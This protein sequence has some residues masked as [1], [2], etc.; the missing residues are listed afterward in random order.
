MRTG[1]I[2]KI[3]S[4]SGKT[5]I[6]STN[7]IKNRLNHYKTYNCKKQYKLYASLKKYGFENH[8][9]EILEEPH[10]NNL[11][12]REHYWGMIYDSLS[13]QGLNLMLPKGDSIYPVMS[14]ETKRK[15]GEANRGR[16][17]KKED[18]AK[19]VANLRGRVLSDKTRQKI[20][21]SLKGKKHSKERR[22]KISESNKG[23]QISEKCKQSTRDRMSKPVLCLKTGVYYNSATEASLA[24]NINSNHLSRMLRGVRRNRTS[25][26]YV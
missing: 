3:T 7:S 20:S 22:R 18:V 10:L 25:L 17:R 4:P 12:A 11:H 21:E 24:Y 26:T 13:K 1:Y 5:Y 8:T 15:I 2:Y 23:R 19:I 9:I 16:K 14:E 6:G